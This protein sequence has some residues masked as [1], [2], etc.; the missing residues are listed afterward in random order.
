M[1]PKGHSSSSHSSG[2]SRSF[3]GS[4]SSSGSFSRSSSRPSS[5]S[6]SSHSSS[7]SASSGR[8]FGSSSSGRPSSHSGTSHTG[9][10]PKTGMASQSRHGPRPRINQ[11][12]GF[13]ISAGRR[14]VYHYARRH[15]YVY[16]PVAWTDS[17]TGMHYERGYYDE[18]GRRYDSVAF[19]KNGR[20]ENVRCH[21]PYC[22]QD[23]VISMESDSP[24]QKELAC[25]H[26]GGMMEIQSAL[27]EYTE[28]G[29]RSGYA[30]KRENRTLKWV[31][32]ALAILLSIFSIR[33]SLQ[34][35]EPALPDVQP[36]SVVDTNSNPQQL[37]LLGGELHLIRH[38]DGTYGI[39]N[40]PIREYDKVL[41]YEAESGNYYDKETDC[42]LWQNTDV[43]PAI[44]GSLAVL[45]R[46][47]FPG[48]RGLWLDGMGRF[49]KNL[50]YRGIRRQLDLSS[51]KV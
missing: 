29:S 49:G 17:G 3:S 2:S 23:T 6:Y 46:R 21:C 50:V 13:V 48:L 20:Y 28:A 39:L 37:A 33:L 9:S 8:S 19:K 41:E 38:S 5:H 30:F 10:A 31:I 35:K 36:I 7:S 40:D 51:R 27:D 25:P 43:T 12:I 32:L 34:K 45:V 4:R 26:C 14:P 42:W 18:I 1:P 47:D 16:Y 44:T 11:P 24:M 15:D 22:E